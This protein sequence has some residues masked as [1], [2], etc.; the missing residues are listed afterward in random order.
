[1]LSKEELLKYP[2]YLLTKYQLEIYRQV[3]NYRQTNDLSKSDLA[4]QMGVSNPYVSQILNGNFNYT[5]KKLIEIGLTIGQIP[6]LN[7]V[8]LK[9]YEIG[10]TSSSNYPSIKAIT[11][12]HT[13]DLQMLPK[14]VKKYEQSAPVSFNPQ[15]K[16][17]YT[18]NDKVA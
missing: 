10:V 11:V 2:D 14:D 5:L 7:F 18:N 12:S 4:K 6:V 13:T 9:E 3:E 15:M 17:V 16:V 1:M 8:P